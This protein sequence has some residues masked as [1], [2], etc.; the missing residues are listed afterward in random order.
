MN[1]IKIRMWSTKANKFFYDSQIFECLMQQNRFDNN[2][3]G[4]A[5]DHISDGMIFEQYIWIKD[6]NEVEICEGDIVKFDNNKTGIV[7][8]CN[9]C[10][11]LKTKEEGNSWYTSYPICNH[12]EENLEIIGNI[13]EDK[14]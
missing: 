13:H 9:G 8:Y 4:L 10:Y 1:N 3:K 6:Y 2:E 5:Y 12:F 14:K 11:F 7:V